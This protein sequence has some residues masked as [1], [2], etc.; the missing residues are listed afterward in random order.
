METN[1]IVLRQEII[2]NYK[3]SKTRFILE[4]Q[5]PSQQMEIIYSRENS[6]AMAL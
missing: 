5:E 4:N 3:G 6:D 1:A 2:R